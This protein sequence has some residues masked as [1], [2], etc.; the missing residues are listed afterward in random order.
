[1]S[2]ELKSNSRCTLTD[3][4]LVE[5]CTEWVQ[6]LIDTGG[7]DWCLPVPAN[8]NKDVDLVLCELIQRF[9][10]N[11]PKADEWVSAKTHP[12]EYDNS[13]ENE[14]MFLLSHYADKWI[15]R[16]YFYNGNYYNDFD[17]DCPCYPTHWQPLP[18]PPNQ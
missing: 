10:N 5:K 15:V 12:P 3:A 16:G 8:P 9:K 17:N 4:E 18:T 2:E 11:A 6:K 14:T 13:N 7:R 1:M